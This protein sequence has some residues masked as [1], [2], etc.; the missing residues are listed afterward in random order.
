MEAVKMSAYSIAIDIGGT[1]TDAVLR[2]KE[3]GRFWV[4][5]TLTTPDDLRQGFFTAVEAVLKR[6]DCRPN[7]VDEAVVHATTIVTNAIIERKG[8]KTALIV[9]E[10]FPDVLVIRDECRSDIF[11]NQLELPKPL[12]PAEFT[13]GL[14]ERTLSNGSVFKK[15]S[16]KAVRKIA[17]QL[18]KAGISSVAVC[19]LN[20]YKNPD[21][22]RQVRDILTEELPHLFVSLSGEV[23]PQMR[24]YPRASTT[25]INAYTVP[26]V[27]PYL[28]GLRA[29]L[30]KAGFQQGLLIMLSSGGVIGAE[31]AG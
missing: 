9:T 11:D 26:I 25:A 22:E 16:K 23:S 30:Q 28:I 14:P 3:D 17:R 10:G 2:N 27:Q 8:P 19:L 6:A 18:K 5:K 24:E 21:N 12:I 4:D 15:V 31:I 7:L 20:A 13:F 1:F 29:D